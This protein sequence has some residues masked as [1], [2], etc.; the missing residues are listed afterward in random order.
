M[1]ATY[2]L[3]PDDDPACNYIYQYQGT[4]AW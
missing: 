3:I 1:S 2:T 4:F